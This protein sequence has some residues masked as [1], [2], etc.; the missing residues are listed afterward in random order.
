MESSG[1]APV[2]PLTFKALEERLSAL[3]EFPADTASP[4]RLVRGAGIVM[5]LAI[6]ST[7]IA[8]FLSFTSVPP[9]LLVKVA[10]AGLRVAL[11][12]LGVL[13][14][15]G[16]YGIASDLRRWTLDQAM[17]TDHQLEQFMQEVTWLQGYLA[18]T[19]QVM[20]DHARYS[21]TRRAA[22]LRYW[23]EASTS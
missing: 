3:P 1:V 7:L 22:A 9:Q 5:A 4:S 21:H 16:I 15:L 18:A 8:S 19:L 10:T 6:A 23:L 2:V 13:M 11:V 14:L 20:L 17:R 12:A